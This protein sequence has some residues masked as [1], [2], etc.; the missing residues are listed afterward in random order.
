MERR[1]PTLHLGPMNF[2]SKV[3]VVD[4]FLG[5]PPLLT[6]FTKHYL[7]LP[8]FTGFYLVLPGFT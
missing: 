7:V 8:G 6:I 4:R 5:H 1:S 3:I 2:L